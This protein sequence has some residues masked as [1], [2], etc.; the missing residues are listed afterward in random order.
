MVLEAIK[1]GYS[2]PAQFITQMRI[3]MK[4]QTVIDEWGRD[5]TVYTGANSLF[6]VIGDLVYLLY[7]IESNHPIRGF[8]EKALVPACAAFDAYFAMGSQLEILQKQPQMAK[9]VEELQARIV[10][11]N[12]SLRA[13]FQN[14]PKLIGSNIKVDIPNVRGG[15]KKRE[16][17]I[18]PKSC[19]PILLTKDKCQDWE[20][21]SPSKIEILEK[22]K[23]SAFNVDFV[24]HRKIRAGYLIKLRF[25]DKNNESKVATYIWDEGHKEKPELEGIL[26]PRKRK[27]QRNNFGNGRPR[28]KWPGFQ[29]KY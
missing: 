23:L 1:A 26:W 17:Y 27:F 10:E 12:N 4:Q 9:Y 21:K 8:I 29:K 2:T 15:D 25:E 16:I 20:N 13:E 3:S 7:A 28:Q 14:I 24:E 19:L 6:K 5:C 18:K 22:L 11:A